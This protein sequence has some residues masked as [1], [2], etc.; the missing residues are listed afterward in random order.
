MAILLFC[1]PPLVVLKIA[2][3]PFTVTIVTSAV[4]ILCRVSL[5]FFPVTALV[6]VFGLGLDYV[7]YAIEG[8]K[9]SSFAIL[10]SFVTTAL[11]FGALA[12]STFPPVHTLGLTVFAGLTTALVTA[13]CLT[14]N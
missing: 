14:K 4:L 7:I 1:Y 9:S 13:L 8:K 2:A 5:S 11:S 6:L 12:L 10:L 3:I